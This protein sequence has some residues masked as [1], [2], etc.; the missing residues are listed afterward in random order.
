MK[1][2]I[3][4]GS[5]LLALLLAF[6]SWA[7]YF[8]FWTPGGVHWLLGKVPRYSPVK[9]QVDRV[10][11]RIAGDL[12]LEGLQVW[13]DGGRLDIQRLQ[14]SLEPLHLLRGK[15]LFEKIIVKQISLEEKQAIPEPLDLS[16][17]RVSG[18]LSR[19]DLEIRS[20]LVEEIRYRINDDPPW[21]IHKMSGRLA[22]NQGTL[23]VNPLEV[24]AGSGPF[25]RLL[26]TGPGGSFAGIGC[27][28]LSG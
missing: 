6:C 4:L 18:F 16:L 19:L 12:K 3:I 13:W 23:A 20:L 21:V 1:R 15:I 28:F 7:L 26:G 10:T 8:L 24:G 5:A 25:E 9:I 27:P 22:W 17:P 11:G 2:W 14:T